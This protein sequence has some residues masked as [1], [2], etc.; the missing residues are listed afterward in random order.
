MNRNKYSLK[1]VALLTLMM[2]PTA[3][4]QARTSKRKSKFEVSSSLLILRIKP[5]DFAS[6]FDSNILKGK[7]ESNLLRFYQSQFMGGTGRQLLLSGLKEREARRLFG[8]TDAWSIVNNLE[9]HRCE[10][11]QSVGI[12]IGSMN[13]GLTHWENNHYVSF[14]LGPSTS[15]MSAS[16]T[17]GACEPLTGFFVNAT[18][19]LGSGR[20]LTWYPGNALAIERIYSTPTIGASLGWTFKI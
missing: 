5:I 18:V 14:S 3:F 20:S 19:A 11:S 9:K 6:G 8:R 15:K 2:I 13:L 4:V 10:Q 16:I 7:S 12:G 17:Q 1:V